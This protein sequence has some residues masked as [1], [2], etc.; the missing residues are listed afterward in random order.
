MYIITSSLLSMNYTYFRLAMVYSRLINIYKT[1]MR[2]SSC[3]NHNVHWLSITNGPWILAASIDKLYHEVLRSWDRYHFWYHFSK[4][5]CPAKIILS[6]LKKLET[7]WHYS[8][9]QHCGQNCSYWWNKY[10]LI[11]SGKYLRTIH[12]HLPQLLASYWYIYIFFCI[13]EPNFIAVRW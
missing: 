1:K 7:I 11:W 3:Y 13:K 9:T 5:I 4:S 8:N 10:H 6:E 12:M 2:G